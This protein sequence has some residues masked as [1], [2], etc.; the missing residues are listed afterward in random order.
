MK[1]KDEVR[2]AYD[3]ALSDAANP[4]TCAYDEC[5]ARAEALGWVINIPYI[6]TRRRIADAERD[7]KRARE[8]VEQ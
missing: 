5:V 8:G 7:N 2:Q 3:K 6:E 1:T 4:L